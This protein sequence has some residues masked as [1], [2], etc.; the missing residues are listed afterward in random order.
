MLSTLVSKLLLLLL[1]DRQGD[2]RVFFTTGY[3]EVYI[4]EYNIIVDEIKQDSINMRCYIQT[5]QL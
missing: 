3:F 5:R 4:A 1:A 2:A